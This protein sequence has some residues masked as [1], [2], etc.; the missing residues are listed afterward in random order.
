MGRRR[1]VILTRNPDPGQVKTRLIPALGPQ[2]AASLHK[3]MTEH[4]LKWASFLAKKS[5]GLLEIRFDGGN[6]DEMAEWLGLEWDYVPQGEGD[7]GDRMA[8]AFRENFQKGR[9]KV[10]IVGTDCPQMTAFHVEKAFD[11]LKS[12]DLVLGPTVDGGYCLIG[13]KRLLPDLFTSM[14]W[15]TET[16]F[17]DTLERAKNAGLSVKSLEPLQDVDVPEDLPVWEKASNQFLSIVIPTLDE[18]VHLGQT[19]ERIGQLSDGEVIVIDGGSKD[20]TVSIAEEWGAKVIR[21]RPNRGEQM[22]RGAREASGDI[23]LFLHAD[24]LL[25]E[26]YPRLI[27]EAMNESGVVGGAFAWKVEPSTPI[28][29]YLELNVAW[30]TRIFR[31]PYGDQAYFVRTS[32]FREIGGYAN[33]PLMEDVEFIRRLRKAGKLVFISKP[34]VTSPRRYEKFGPVRTALRNKLALFGYYLGIPPDRLAKFYYKK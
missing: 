19:L 30:R 28:L 13:L 6:R 31:M 21:T 10:V 2:K 3:K 27:R 16:V 14:A 8:G 4:T 22:N 15:G 1:L 24:T 7:L 12:H 33:I 11:A 9:E 29:R 32:V 25:S 18:K 34:V 26:D 20:D 5:S 17:Q 23:L